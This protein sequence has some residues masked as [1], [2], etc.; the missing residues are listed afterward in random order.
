MKNFRL[1]S[2]KTTIF[3]LW[4]VILSHGKTIFDIDILILYN[5]VYE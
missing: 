3:L 5:I 2:K 4:K 1:I